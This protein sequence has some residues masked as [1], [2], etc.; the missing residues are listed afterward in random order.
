M[1]LMYFMSMIVYMDINNKDNPDRN[2]VACMVFALDRVI[3]NKM[4]EEQKKIVID[5]II[6][7]EDQFLAKL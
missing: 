1:L 3:R 4:S 5:N 2:K 7:L 6:A